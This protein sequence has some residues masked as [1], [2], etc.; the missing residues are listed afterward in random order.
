MARRLSPRARSFLAA[1]L[2]GRREGLDPEQVRRFRDTGTAHLIAISGLHV[3]FLALVLNPLIALAGSRRNLRLLGWALCLGSFCL[4]T[5]AAAPV[6]R[7]SLMIVCH[8]IGSL[9]GSHDG[10]LSGWCLGLTAEALLR[11]AAVLDPGFTLSYGAAAALILASRRGW[12]GALGVG[13][14]AGGRRAGAPTRLLSKVAG[15]V[16]GTIRASAVVL[17]ATG[18]LLIAYFGRWLPLSILHNIVM[19][20]AAGL[21]LA[22]GLGCLALG[23]LPGFPGLAA[24]SL[25]DR[26]LLAFLRLQALTADYFPNLVLRGGLPRGLAVLLAALITLALLPADWGRRGRRLLIVC[27]AVTA[28]LN[29]V[30]EWEPPW[31]ATF[32]SLGRGEAIVLHWP[33][34]KTWLVDTGPGGRDGFDPAIIPALRGLGIRRLDTIFVT[35]NQWDHCGALEALCRTYPVGRILTGPGGSAPHRGLPVERVISEVAAGWREE[36]APG[37]AAAVLHPP[38]AGASGA[39]DSSLVIRI[40]GWGMSLLLTGD[41]EAGGEAALL[42]GGAALRSRILKLGHHGR[43]TSTTPAFLAAVDPEAAIA[44][45]SRDAAGPEGSKVLNRIRECGIM[46]VDAAVSGS[47]E[48]REAF[49]HWRLAPQGGREACDLG[50][51]PRRGFVKVRTLTCGSRAR[52]Q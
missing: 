21:V 47:I 7:A 32:L 42:A 24:W 48:L 1:F 40:E 2:L 27:L 50:P 43:E 37:V 5:G 16:V 15:E 29:L 36:P 34:G 30:P 12:L 4:L 49:G 26:L 17:T 6:C 52:V 31:R 28:G 10:A 41:L 23:F 20:P 35:H 19:I 22:A 45:G 51:F 13:P 25:L 33:G 18:P 46:P 38:G 3:G 14:A 39:N 44:L 9:R 8:Q 11:P